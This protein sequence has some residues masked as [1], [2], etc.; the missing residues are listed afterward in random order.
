MSRKKTTSDFIEEARKV[1][2]DKYDYSKVEYKNTDTKVCIIC[3]KHGEFWQKPYQHLQGNGC[4]TCYYETI[5]DRCRHTKD[6]FEQRARKV[7][8]DKY[9]YSKVEYINQNTQ[10]CIICPKHGKFW[11]KPS[12]HINGSECPKCR[13]M[14][15][16]NR[17]WIIR[18]KMIHG[19]KYDY[20]KVNYVN[21]VT[22]VC[23]ICPQHGEFYTNPYYHAKGVGCP[24][25]NGG[26]LKLTKKMKLSLLSEY[27]LTSMSSHQLLELIATDAFPKEWEKLTYTEPNSD[28]RKDSI[29]ELKNLYSNATDDEESDIETQ[30]KLEEET[31]Q[32]EKEYTSKKN[33]QANLDDDLTH[34][35]E[36]NFPELEEKTLKNYSK[37]YKNL[38]SLGD[39]HRFIAEVEIH[40]IW[41][42]VLKELSQKSDKTLS[43]LSSME[44]DSEWLAYVKD[45]FFTEF[46]EVNEITV[47]SEY[48]FPYQP[49]LMQK[50]MVY[51]LMKNHSYG[52]WCGTGAYLI[53]LFFHIFCINNVVVIVRR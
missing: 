31:R 14:K 28:K 38:I 30:H 11:Q 26:N 13:G 34:S 15:M 37:A 1:H 32:L 52:N 48:A 2:G 17:D 22:K 46:N 16:N 18:F 41:N 23:V 35:T 3:P 9:D 39:K 53:E 29:A 51:R 33:K 7:H 47:D 50:L 6:V 40:K 45:T 42:A 4:K 8:G 21:A 19:D 5:G 44:I 36:D 49:S 43:M 12:H 25:C 27:D 24:I 10:V 20:A